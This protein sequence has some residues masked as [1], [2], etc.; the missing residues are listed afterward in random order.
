[1]NLDSIKS[2]LTLRY[3]DTQTPILPKLTSRDLIKKENFSIENIHSQLIS[4]LQKQIPNDYSKPISISLSGGVDSSLLLCILKESFPDNQI[5]AI[6]IKFSDSVDET[7][8]ASQIAKKVGVNHHIVEVDNYL[9][10]LSDAISITKLPFWDIH[11]YYIVENAKHFSNYLVSG[12]G[13]D[14]L[15]GGYI[16]RYS[17]FLSKIHPNSTVND[18]I[19]AYLSCHERDHVPDQDDIFTKKMEFNWQVI[20]DKLVP[21]FDNE[22]SPLEQVFL[23]DYNGKL[24]Y[25]FSIVNNSLAKSFNIQSITPLLFPELIQKSM[26]IS[27]NQKYDSLSNIGKLPLRKILEKFGIN[28]LVLKQKQGFSVNTKN[29]WKNHGLTM[30]NHYLSDAKIIQDGWINKDWIQSNLNDQNIDVRH[31]NK[32]LGLLA[33]EIWYRQFSKT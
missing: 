2:I 3:D 9:E 27:S 16:F 12:D 31:I 20:Y 30:A 17:K 29:L 4:Y 26:K 6:S 5:D 11:W 33:F 25:N 19:Q 23:A 1:M 10:K 13:G 32:L 8:T 24:L 7:E 21:F 15:F 18:K 22:L 28:D 14:E